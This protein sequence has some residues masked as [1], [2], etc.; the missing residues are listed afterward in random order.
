MAVI[1]FVILFF[2]LAETNADYILSQRAKRL[3]KR[4]GDQMLLSR[5]ESHR[6][7]KNWVRLVA[8]HLTVS[9]SSLP[10]LSSH[11][12]DTDNSQMPF[13]IT[14]LDPSIGFIN[15]YTALVYGVYYSFFESFPLVYIGT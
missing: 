9:L 6:G 7:K 10:S 4:T 15:L 11:E 2:F 1:T 12:E 8:Y 3:R 14:V 5:T 13:R